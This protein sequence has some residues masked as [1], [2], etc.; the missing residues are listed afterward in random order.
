MNNTTLTNEQK[1]DE[2]Y[3]IIRANERRRMQA[4][5]GRIVKWV[6]I[7]G[8]VSFVASNPEIFVKKLTEIIQPIVMSQVEDMMTTNKDALMESMKDMLPKE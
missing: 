8:F 6:M 7:I 5:I 1:L 2:I 4:S 3:T